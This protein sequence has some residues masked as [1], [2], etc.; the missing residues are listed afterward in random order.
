M[1]TA[2]SFTCPRCNRT[3][4]HPSDVAHQYCGACHRYF[5]EDILN[6]PLPLS[7]D[8]ADELLRE[9]KN[10]NQREGTTQ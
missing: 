6:A 2:S 4:H 8:E 1:N 9:L 5:H 10:R 7:A 3:S